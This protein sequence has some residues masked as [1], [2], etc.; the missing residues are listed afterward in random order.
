MQNK[1]LNAACYGTV[2]GRSATNPVLIKEMEYEL[3]QLTHYPIIHFNNDATACY[4]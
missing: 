2:P 4:D 3:A 1:L